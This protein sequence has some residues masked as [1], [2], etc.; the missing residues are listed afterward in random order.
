MMKE[1]KHISLSI[2]VY[3]NQGTTKADVNLH[4]SM[5]N[6]EETFYFLIQAI[7]ELIKGAEKNGSKINRS[8]KNPVL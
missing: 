6:E 5:D 3:E 7:Q 8:I 2:L 4:S 1:N